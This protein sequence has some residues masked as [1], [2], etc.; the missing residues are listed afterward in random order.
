MKFGIG[1]IPQKNLDESVKLVKLAEEMGFE[2]AWI[3]DN[4]DIDIYKLLRNALLETESIKIGP[5]VVNPYIRKPGKL[6]IELMNLNKIS[7]NRIILG[8]GPGNKPQLDRLNITWE[9]PL[10]TL[11]RSINVVRD[12]NHN[13]PDHMIPIYVESP[14]NELLELAGKTSDGVLI[15]SSNPKD[16]ENISRPIQKGLAN[17]KK[18]IDD[19]EVIAY[20][21]TSIGNDAEIA[22]N[23]SRIAVAFI[24]AGSPPHILERHSIPE[25]VKNDIYLSLSKGDIGS[26]MRLVSDDF[27]DEFSIAGSPEDII[28]K[29]KGLEKAGAAQYVAG[30]PIGRDIYESVRLFG[31]VIST[32]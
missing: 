14:S 20:G 1:L 4:P 21:A 2:Y 28:Q 24:I 7:N 10:T 5:G 9:K 8:I 25:Q 31:D 30:A 13:N 12:M 18:E 29:I 15:N 32:Y 6:S 19:F 17:S 26:A 27:I 3:S 11:K 23:A 16:Y 22:R